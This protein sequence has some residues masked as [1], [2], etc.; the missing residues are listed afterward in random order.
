M[1]QNK[2]TN[3]N[4]ISKLGQEASDE[5]F[6][7]GYSGLV[8]WLQNLGH[9]KIIQWKNSFLGE[10]FLEIG[11]GQGGHIEDAD[12]LS[13]DYIGSDLSYHNL[14]MYKQRYPFLELVNADAASLPFAK[15]S[16]DNLISIYNLEHIRSL[17][18]C[19]EEINRIIVK[20]GTLLIALPAEGGFLYKL[21]R[22]LTTKRYMEKNFDIDYD[23]V[24]RE[25]HVND[26][27]TLIKKLR[28][29]FGLKKIRYLPFSFFPSYHF[30]AFVCIKAIN[31]NK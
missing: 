11:I 24:I 27:P 18:Q 14:I 15:N 28:K 8:G 22:E 5:L 3:D 16:F 10:R 26:Y 13:S 19:L 9:K 31:I 30:N 4:D 29:V 6:E 23:S 7:Y 12:L 20:N 21:G 1:N 25:S 2:S 17:D